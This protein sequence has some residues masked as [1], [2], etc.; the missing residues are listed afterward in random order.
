MVVACVALAIALSGAS[1]AAIVL[2]KNSVGTKQLRKNAVTS[3]K[4]KNN[5]IT[6]AKVNEAT[7]GTVPSAATAGSADALDG[8][9]LLRV[10][11]AG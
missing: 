1:Y 10:R 5:A 7:L 4:V 3:A 2:P 8:P 11:E 6:G 9:R